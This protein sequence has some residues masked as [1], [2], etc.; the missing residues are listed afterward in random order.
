M[1]RALELVVGNATAPGSTFTA[2]TPAAGNSFQV[3]SA[4][5]T[6]DI[7][8]IAAWANNNAA[9][10]LRIRSPR[11][12]DNVQGIRMNVLASNP[13]PLYPTSRSGAFSQKLIAQDTLIVELT[14]SATAGQIE[15]GA[16]LI[17][18]AD[19]PGVAGRFIDSAMLRKA[20]VSLMAQEV[21]ITAGVAGGFS[22]A[23][24]INSTFDNF[25]ANTDYAIIGYMVSG[26]VG[27]VRV[28]GIDTGNL[29]VGGPGTGNTNGRHQTRDWFQ[30]LSD[31]TGAAYIPVYA[32]QNKQGITVDVAAS[33]AG[34]TFIVTLFM[35]ELAPGSV[36][37]TG[38]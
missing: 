4:D 34:G 12:H 28:T 25:K 26:V 22:G 38:K 27:A 35:V 33:Q 8:L 36:T 18:Y 16:F 15:T 31:S 10:T 17:T 19:L 13:E 24:A 32:S 2:L 30:L 5:I 14:G 3:R 7:R 21:S 11:L 37:A 9:G 29:G 23:V 6:S 20:G 1:P